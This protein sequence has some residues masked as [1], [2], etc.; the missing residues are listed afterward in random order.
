[1][2]AAGT[3][4]QRVAIQR[5]T[6]TRDSFGAEVV[7]WTDVATVWASVMALAGRELFDSRQTVAQVDHRVTIRHRADVRPAMRVVCGVRVFDIQAALDKEGRGRYLE[8]LCR[9]AV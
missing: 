8:L 9:E 4:R 1:M 5:Q 6:V 3:L 7:T 2:M